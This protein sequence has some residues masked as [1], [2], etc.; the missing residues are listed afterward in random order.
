V[1]QHG[2]ERVQGF[3]PAKTKTWEQ[4]VGLYALQARQRVASWPL[5]GR[6]AV[7]LE[8]IRSDARG[9]LD[10]MVKSALDGCNSILWNDDGQVDGIQAW[11]RSLDAQGP[12]LV[13]LVAVIGR[14]GG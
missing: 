4:M 9:D 6:Y 1:V 3:T 7:T 2:R 14:A 11:R 8:V 12:R 13:M 10:N 5:G